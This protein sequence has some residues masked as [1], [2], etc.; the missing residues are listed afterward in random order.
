MD[1]TA[2]I[3]LGILVEEAVRES[4]GASGDMVFTEGEPASL[5]V[6][7]D[8][9]DEQ[10]P[11]SMRSSG[12]NDHEMIHSSSTDGDQTESEAVPVQPPESYPRKRQNTN[13][14]R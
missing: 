13:K 7:D 2:L 4:L 8:D 10:L 14:S 9:D 5:P 1:G 12:P 3:A 6:L 11:G